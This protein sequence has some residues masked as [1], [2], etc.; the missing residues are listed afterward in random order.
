VS[1]ASA[2]RRYLRVASA[3]TAQLEE[4]AWPGIEA[5]AT[6]L[7]DAMAGGAAIHVFGTGH[8]HM[9]AEE[10]SYRAGGL[11]RV[12][13]ILFEGL[14]LHASAPLSTVLER[15]PGL[16]AALLEDHPLAKGDVL[17]IASNSGGN[18]VVTEMA[19]LARDHGVAVIAITSL[20]HATSE[21]ARARQEV[22]LHDLADVVIDN[23]GS[24]GDAVVRIDGL[25]T[26]VGPTSTVVGAAIVNALVAETVERL[27]HAG[28]TPDVF[29][30]ANLAGGDDL[31]ARIL[32]DEA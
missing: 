24:V 12:Q 5:G 3:L 8:S 17:I 10:M 27:V 15:L 29:T 13:P 9:L 4:R 22:H 16:A 26:A 11:A 7:A 20:T 31:N 6:L 28:F 32:S 19:R 30:S 18:A 2:G 23:G 25:P 14:M 21:G 1:D